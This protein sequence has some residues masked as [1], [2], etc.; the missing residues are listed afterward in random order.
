MQLATSTLAESSTLSMQK[1]LTEESL[2]DAAPWI[3]QRLSSKEDDFFRSNGKHFHLLEPLVGAIQFVLQY[4]FVHEFEVPY[5]W[6]HK[7]DFITYFSESQDMRS[8]VDLLSQEDLWRIAALG[9]KYRSLLERR[10]ALE[11]LYTRLG[12]SDEYFE[13]E[14]RRKVDSVEVV[15][16]ATEWLTMKYKD[17]SKAKD[18]FELHFHDDDDDQ[19][20]VKK[21]KL[22]SR[23][24]A[25]EIAKQTVVSKLAQVRDI[26]VD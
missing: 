23:I 1:Q 11:S 22:P 3:V 5:I 20:D 26:Y 25:Y 7:R 9:Q 12:A 6:A 14:V 19:V 4:L 2:E 24:S 17:S 15:A 16:D 10:K 21:R 8:R 18:H 13:G